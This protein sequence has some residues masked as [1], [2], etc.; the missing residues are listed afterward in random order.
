M[1]GQR[2]GEMQVPLEA[3]SGSRMT[4]RKNMGTSALQ[5]QGT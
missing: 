5:L 1:D 2:G 3:E 4:A